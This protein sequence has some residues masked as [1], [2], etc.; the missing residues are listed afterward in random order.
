MADLHLKSSKHFLHSKSTTNMGFQRMSRKPLNESRCACVLFSRQLEGLGPLS[1]TKVQLMKSNHLRTWTYMGMHRKHII[2]YVHNIYIY[3]YYIFHNPP[4]N[5]CTP[6]LYI[7]I[8][9]SCLL[10]GLKYAGCISS[11]LSTAPLR[12][13]VEIAIVNSWILE[14]LHLKL[15]V[16]ATWGLDHG[17]V[18]ISTLWF[19]DSGQ[20]I[21][22]SFLIILESNRQIRKTRWSPRTRMP[23]RMLRN[24]DNTYLSHFPANPLVRHLDLTHRG[25]TLVGH[26]CLTL[27][28][29][30][31]VRHSCKTLCLDTSYLTHLNDTLTWHTWTTLLL[32][33]LARHSYV[34]LV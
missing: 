27:M 2:Y 12:P 24:R 20:N 14:W 1:W 23:T 28:R 8:H 32:D 19:Q 10:C 4:K 6:S 31:L 22:R 25:D 11:W 34:T 18:E 16:W 26:P 9:F 3:V 15:W 5:I 29:K 17:F 7:F 33:T 30:A 13:P 21:S